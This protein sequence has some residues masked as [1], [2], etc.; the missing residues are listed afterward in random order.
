[1]TISTNSTRDMWVGCFGH[2]GANGNSIL[3]RNANGIDL[4][5]TGYI[6]YSNDAASNIMLWTSTTGNLNLTGTAQNMLTVAK[7]IKIGNNTD[8]A[9]TAGGGSFKYASASGYYSNA[10][11]WLALV[12][13]VAG[14]TKVTAAAPYTNDGY[15]EVTIE[16]N[17]YKLMTTA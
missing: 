12:G 2:G 16:G 15:I 6:R 17:T 3:F 11:N 10:S 1:M 9:A 5:S 13:M 7:G 8:S 4:I 14:N